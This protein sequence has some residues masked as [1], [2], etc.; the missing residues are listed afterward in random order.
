[1][2]DGA[3][4]RSF[5]RSLWVQAFIAQSCVQGAFS[6]AHTERLAKNTASDL[7]FEALMRAVMRIIAVATT[8]ENQLSSAG[9]ET[10]ADRQR[11][12]GRLGGRERLAVPDGLAAAP[13][14]AG[15]REGSFREARGGE[16]DRAAAGRGARVESTAI[17]RGDRLGS[18]ALHVGGDGFDGLHRRLSGRA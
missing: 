11:G 13:G 17:A 6:T 1:M 5:L 9:G 14:E 10:G 8:V 16:E 3:A 15:R 18:S 4:R 12:R 7:D 2:G